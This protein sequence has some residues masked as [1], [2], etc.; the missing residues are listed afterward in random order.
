MNLR[1]TWGEEP[2]G[3]GRRKLRMNGGEYDG[4]ILKDF[5]KTLIKGGLERKMRK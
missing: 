5:S 4:S 2:A 1:G 3:G